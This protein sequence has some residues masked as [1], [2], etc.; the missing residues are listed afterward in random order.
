MSGAGNIRSFMPAQPASALEPAI[1]LLDAAREVWLLGHVRP[2][3]D[4]LGSTLGLAQSLARTGKT[5][6]VFNQDPVPE[7]LRFLPGADTVQPPPPSLPP[8]VVVA[9]LDTS[10]EARLGPAFA[11][12]KR[13]ADLNLDHHESN[14]GY[15][16]LNLVDPSEPSTAS[17]VLRLIRQAGWPLGADAAANLYTGLLTDTGSFRYRGTTAQTLRAAADLVEAGADPA[18]LASACYQTISPTRFALRRLAL[19]NLRIECGGKLSVIDL[20]PESF[21]TS[22]ATPEDTEGLVEEALTMRTVEVA[23]LF[24]LKAGG[25]LKVSLRSKGRINVSRLAQEFGGGGHPGAAGINF[26]ANGPEHRLA[27]LQRLGTLFPAP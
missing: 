2:D 1:R 7:W 27:I 4:A 18:A 26:P 19:Q 13:T 9:A 21:S 25:A 11:A 12:W 20:T 15:G 5:V 22:G 14:T 17:L 3:G 6:R 23:V 16:T 24:E 10:T 8:E